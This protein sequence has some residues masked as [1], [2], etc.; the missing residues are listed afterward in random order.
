[1]ADRV[2][3]RAGAFIDAMIGNASA[4]LE[5]TALIKASSEIYGQHFALVAGRFN[6]P[7]RAYSIIEQVRGRIATDLLL[8][9]SISSDEAR[10]AERAI[11][12]LRLKLIGARSTDEIR[13]IRDQIFMAEQSQWVTPGVSILKAQAHQTIGADR[14]SKSLTSSAVVLEYVLAE[15][16][17]YCLVISRQGSRIVPLAGRH[18]HGRFGGRI[19]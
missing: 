5:K 18:P 10:R 6:D 14:V 4:V 12:R 19:S 15:P 3:D 2:Y 9:G 11:S 8:A 16:R 7:A 13:R 1:M 17:S